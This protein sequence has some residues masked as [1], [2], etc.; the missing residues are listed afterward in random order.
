MAITTRRLLLALGGLLLATAIL[1]LL[2]EPTRIAGAIAGG[3]GVVLLTAGLRR[4][5]A[6]PASR[7]ESDHISE[8]SD[9]RRKELMRG[10]SLFLREMRYRYSVRLDAHETAERRPFSAEV[11]SIRLGFLPAVIT[12]NK[13]DRQ[14]LGLVAFVHDGRRWRGPGLPCPAT[15]TP[16][17]ST[18]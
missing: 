16:S 4:S 6:G 1:L 11:N 5:P 2:R 18:S 12:D 8:L 13:N 3:G 15:S 7:D 10:T 14:G 9:A 17:S